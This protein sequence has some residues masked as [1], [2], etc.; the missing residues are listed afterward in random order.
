MG[1]ACN[2][3]N[4]VYPPPADGKPFRLTMG[5]R[6]LAPEN[7]LEN[8]PDLI[9]QISYR[10][11]LASEN[12]SQVY[13][14]IAGHEEAANYFAKLLLNNLRQYH[15]DWKVS[16]TD[17]T[18]L[19]LDLSRKITGPELLFN[20][21]LLIGEDLAL[22]KRDQ[23][24]WTL[25]EAAIFFPSRWN[26]LE[27]IGKGIDQIH[28]PLPG[29]ESALAPYMS[30]TFDT[31]KS[32]RPVW[33]KNWSLHSSRELHQTKSIHQDVAPED[34]WWRTERQT[35]TKDAT[36]EYLLFTIRNRVE[37]FAWIK[38]DLIAAAEFA[39]TFASIS[40]EILSYK[41]LLADRDRLLNY[42]N[43]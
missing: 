35:L 31:I 8:G 24:N 41:G 22:L 2:Q 6:E 5:L 37:P 34:Y 13:Q 42:L 7:W 18:F 16:E 9:E 11:K 20:L 29:Y 23:G 21:S 36:G 4:F 39:K 19:P 40:D 33:R 30:K 15:Q 1:E 14:Q 3:A 10:S 26:L 43:S 12:R 25:V 38:N 28:A 27:K 17:L 32:E